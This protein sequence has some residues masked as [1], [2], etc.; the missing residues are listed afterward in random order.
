MRYA[1]YGRHT[2]EVDLI[3]PR[4]AIIEEKQ[5]IKKGSTLEK[6]QFF[7]SSH[8]YTK[9]SIR[10]PPL[11]IPGKEKKETKKQQKKKQKKRRSKA[12]KQSKKQS[13]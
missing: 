8:A 9:T 2:N 3:L 6:A 11:R 7:V 5:E 10:T 4:E 1:V 13:R 12:K